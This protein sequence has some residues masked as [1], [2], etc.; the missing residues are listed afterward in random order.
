M[1]LCELRNH[2][3]VECKLDLQIMVWSDDMMDGCGPRR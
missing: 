3:E 2:M 1:E